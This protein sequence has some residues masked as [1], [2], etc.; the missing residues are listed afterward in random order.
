MSRQ[1][2]V[3]DNKGDESAQSHSWPSYTALV[4][5][6]GREINLTVQTHE[7]KIVV[8]H[9]IPAIITKLCFIDFYPSS[10]TRAAWHKK[11]LNSAASVMKHGAN[12]K[13]NAP[14]A[15]RYE[16][17]QERLKAD[18]D[19]SS[20]LG[21]IVRS[22]I[23]STGLADDDEQLDGRIPI[24]RNNLKA[25][26]EEAAKLHFKLRPGCANE[27][28]WYLSKMRYI[29]PCDAAV[30]PPVFSTPRSVLTLL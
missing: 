27:V 24:F 13:N 6:P 14:I 9:A 22:R 3:A 20:L 25:S 26:A 17:I 12:R 10:T 2:R 18:D 4:R 19:Y 28:E 30:S 16:A 29:Y 11:T 7:V 5:G 15:C 21:K 1:H 8:R 23:C